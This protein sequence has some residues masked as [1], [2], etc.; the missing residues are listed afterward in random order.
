MV[1]GPV[2]VYTDGSCFGNGKGS[3]RAGAGIYAG[4]QS[5]LNASLRVTGDQTNNRG[6]LLAILCAL[7]TVRPN[8]TLEI[9]SD[10]EYAIRSIAYWAVDHAQKGWRC[11]N[12]DLLKDIVSWIKFRS[13]PISFHHVKAHSG[14]G[15]NDAADIAAKAGAA[16]P[17]PAGQYVAFQAPKDPLNVG[18]VLQAKKVFCDLPLNSEPKVHEVSLGTAPPINA[19]HFAPH[20][21]R[22]LDRAIRRA[23][24]KRLTDVSSNSASFWKAYRA[25]TSPRKKILLLLFRSLLRVLRPE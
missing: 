11:A 2:K 15:H 18:P 23:N 24:L 25:M 4:P 10:S 8:R 13:A 3:A 1:G 21:G 17:L 5:S 6:E 22:A 7:S 20:R 19:C 9:Y 16:M 14:N 12:A